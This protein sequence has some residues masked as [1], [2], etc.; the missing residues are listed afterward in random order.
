MDGSLLDRPTPAVP[1][2]QSRMQFKLV[3]LHAVWHPL[4]LLEGIQA[5]G[6]FTVK[7]GRLRIA[8]LTSASQ[9]ISCFISTKALITASDKFSM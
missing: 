7:Q 9:R 2:T 1:L 3:V 4:D 8:K 6:T 5:G